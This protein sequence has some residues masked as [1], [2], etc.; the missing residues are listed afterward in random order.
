MRKRGSKFSLQTTRGALNATTNTMQQLL[1]YSDD[2][3]VEDTTN[4]MQQ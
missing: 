2:A 1:P 3:D 4:T